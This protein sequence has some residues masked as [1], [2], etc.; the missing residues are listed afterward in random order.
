MTNYKR[1]FHI[2]VLLL[3]AFC[4]V[5]CTTEVD[6]TMGS[7]F[8]PTSQNMELKRRVYERGVYRDNASETS[9]SFVRTKLYHTDSIRSANIGEGYFGSEYSD[10]YGRRSAGFMSQ[11]IFSLSL[12][13]ERGWGYRPIYDSMLL[14]LYITDYHGDTT[15]K[16]RFEVYEI[17]SNNYFDLPKE[18]D[19][20][21]YIN[22]DPTPYISSKPIFEF[23][24][25]DQERGVYVG[26]KLNP[27][28]S[29]VRLESTETTAEYISRLMLTTDLD[30][31]G[32]MALDKD[33]IYVQGN[34]AKFLEQVR[35][36]YIKPKDSDFEG[37]DGVMFA[38]NLE[39]TA[40]LLYARGRYEEDPAIIRDTTYMVYN[41]YLDPDTYNVNVGNVSINEVKH[42]FEASKVADTES[43][44]STCYVDAMGGVVTEVE[45]TDEFIQ[46]LADIVCAEGDNAV[47]S[48]NQAT[49]SVY[50]EGS[51]YDY[52]NLVPSVVAPLL[53]AAMPRMGCYTSYNKLIA[54][55][56]YVYTLET[57]SATLKYDG[58]LNRSLA[59]YTMDIS[60]YLQS[61]MNAAAEYV[62]ENGRVDFERF[63]REEADYMSQR[64]F[65]L[66]PAAYSLYGFNRQAIYGMY[67]VDVTTA[68]IKLELTYTV[69]D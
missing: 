10:V 68:P 23:T 28:N 58:T 50:L 44:R 41:L 29:D 39:N 17:T 40:L 18:K 1:I 63:E 14:S 54:I 26:D 57:G 32:G 9:C 69:V 43:L 31:N 4:V 56:D 27:T 25:P 45:F 6:Y 38:T 33:S 34:E 24:F 5:G 60:L 15:Q 48:V 49:M 64:R 67:D 52:N 53:D 46:S 36:I 61:L 11:M 16:H 55:T 62:D 42:N 47:V 2:A 19:T 22:F 21:F 59:C 8:V 13:E 37:K 35:G 7:E 66:A 65:Y 12:P 30:A 20:A 3:V 51:D